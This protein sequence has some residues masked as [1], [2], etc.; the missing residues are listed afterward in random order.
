MV[1]GLICDFESTLYIDREEASTVAGLRRKMHEF[2][3]YYHC[4]IRKEMQNNMKDRFL[5]KEFYPAQQLN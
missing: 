2:A 4:L 1:L 5:I 3:Q